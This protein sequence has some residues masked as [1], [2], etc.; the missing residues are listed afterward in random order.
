M[1]SP[2]NPARRKALRV[3]ALLATAGI[4]AIPLCHD[5]LHT[6]KF[7]AVPANNKRLPR[8]GKRVCVL[9]GGMAGLQTA[10]E[11]AN[12]GYTCTV[13]ER[14]GTPGGKVKSWRDTHFGPADHPVRRQPGF[15]GLPRDHGLHA[16]WGFYDNLREFMGR[17]GFPLQD[18]PDNYSMYTFIDASGT[19]NHIADRHL[20]APY[21]RVEQALQYLRFRTGGDSDFGELLRVITKLMS[22]DYRDAAKRNRMDAMTLADFLRAEGASPGVASYFEGILDMAF[23]AGP[24][25]TSALSVACVFQLL[26]GD[27]SDTSVNIF[28]PSVGET[29]FAPLVARLRA[30]GSEI[31]YHAS[32][33][34]L[35]V[36]QGFVTA[37]VTEALPSSATRRCEICGGVIYGDDHH[38]HCPYCGAHGDQ[39]LPVGAEERQSRTFTADHFVCAMDVPG[40]QQLLA[41]SPSIGVDPYFDNIEHLK[42]TSVYVVDLWYDDAEAWR[43]RL[44]SVQPNCGQFFATGF[45]YIGQT[46]NWAR[47]GENGE[48][49][50]PE[51]QGQESLSVLETHIADAARVA[52]LPDDEIARRVHG[53]L[54]TVMPGLPP[55]RDFYI[56][57]WTNY[58]AYAPGTERL[59]PRVESPIGNLFMAGDWVNVDTPALYMEKT[60]IAARQVCNVI[61]ARDGVAGADL[62]IL[63]SG[64]PHGL[65]SILRRLG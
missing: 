56:N 32:V 3:L 47:F 40:V 39:L 11:L 14:S 28:K 50:I 2:R 48:N 45:E 52:G 19:T 13:L 10:L 29:F 63:D 38:E 59:R 54:A 37:V 26:S 41:R 44:D 18:L 51:Y 25:Q 30:A 8:N 36:E 62:E 23:Y 24:E 16:I 17:Y 49:W 31:L 20:P 6:A 34:H 55:Y 46:I 42:T 22:F 43:T 35:V 15:R 65:G 9:G 53:E 64:V 27:A 61:L 4:A 58:T 7:P 57:K 33:D 1:Q 60:N 12:R 5:G 21:A